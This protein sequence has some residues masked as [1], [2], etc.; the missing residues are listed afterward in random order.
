[1]YERILYKCLIVHSCNTTAQSSNLT[2]Y[3]VCVP[4]TIRTHTHVITYYIYIYVYTYTHEYIYM[5]ILCIYEYLHTHIHELHLY[6]IICVCVCV[7][8][9]S[10]D[11]HLEHLLKQISLHG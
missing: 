2:V 1:M 11:K 8:C 6:V 7:S 9:I 10:T 5:H 4:T 3:Y